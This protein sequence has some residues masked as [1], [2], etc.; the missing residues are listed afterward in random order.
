[1]FWAGVLL[2]GLALGIAAGC[3]GDDDGEAG[4][5]TGAT[6]GTGTPA[7]QQGG[8]LRINLQD[9]TD[10]TDPALA[11]YQVS[12]QFEYMTGVTLLN[13]A[14]APAP[15]GARL[16]PEG[17]E[18]LPVVSDDGKTYT[19]TIRDGFE[20]SPPSNEPVTA[21]SYVRAFERALDPKQQS[22]GASFARDIVGAQEYL[23]GKAD[24]ISG[25]TVDGNTLTFELTEVAPDFLSRVAM[26]F[27]MAVPA[28]TPISPKGLNTVPA[29]GPYYVSSRT[30][31]R[32][33][34]LE[35][36]P[37]YTGD[38]VANFDRIVYT[39]GVDLQQGLL[40]IR[41][42]QA[43]Y[44]ADGVPPASNG[45]LGDQYG[46]DSD[47]AANGLQQYFVNPALTVNYLAL[48]TS[49]DLF[50]DVAPRQAVNYA[51]DRLSILRQS[52]AY[53]GTPTDQ[54]LPPLVEGYKD[55]DLFPMTPDVDKAKELLG[56]GFSGQAVLYTC[57][58]GS[59]PER[60]QII[61][62]NL[63]AV[64][65]DVEIKTFERAVQFSKEGTRGEPFDIADEGWIADYPDPYDF[66]NI[67][68]DGNNIQ[69]TN[70]VNFAYFDE[71]EWNQKM[72]EAAKL[73]GDERYARYGDLDIELARDA[74]PWAATF[75]SNN[76]DFFSE[77]I[78]CQ[79]YQPIYGM[80][81]AP[82][83]VRETG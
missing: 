81:L 10:Y 56:E 31:A 37:N 82:L 66:I 74:A 39:V 23:D 9:D 53:A 13:Y 76:R 75:I 80:S 69:A 5:T 61:Q 6:E 72:V 48:N 28:D 68:L 63:A 27:F 83:C 45:E 64:G 7:A 77:R 52:G 49:R 29:A 38:R 21:Q 73:S 54:Y 70:N 12:W 20:F 24:S 58:A 46:A 79:V 43:D 60:A 51:I 34:V 32:Q 78:G 1:M 11:Y 55:E 26:M 50:G 67:L 2:A 25:I 15:E 59:C 40:Q 4:G 62:S 35:K 14:D 57:N 42:G 65:I 71:P 22:P 16:I 8:T 47:A 33:F 18:D 30:P 19:F 41:N 36:N 17:A 3:G 44:A